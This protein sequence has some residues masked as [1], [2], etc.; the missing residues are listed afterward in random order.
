MRH[1]VRNAKLGRNGS[2]RTALIANLVKSLIKHKRITTTLAKAKVVAPVAEKMVTLAKSGTIHDRRLA[3]SRLQF[4][5]R[6]PYQHK[7]KAHKEAYRTYHDVVRI[8]FD[9][10][11]PQF[12]DRE[13]G[14]TRIVRLTE[15]RR[16]DAGEQAMLMWVSESNDSAASETPQEEA[17]AAP[18]ETEE[19]VTADA[20][21]SSEESK[22]SK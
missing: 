3:A 2:H 13:G 20:D 11:G 4:Q 19:A 9:E 16:G 5:S 15:K 8:L 21:S 17:V 10:I 22:E 6:N 12:K 14:Y 1:R 7:S 18:A